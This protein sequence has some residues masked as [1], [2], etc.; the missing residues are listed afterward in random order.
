MALPDNGRQLKA[1]F[2]DRVELMELDGAG[3][4]LLPERPDAIANAVLAFIARL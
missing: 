2:G 4:A 3:H 1:E